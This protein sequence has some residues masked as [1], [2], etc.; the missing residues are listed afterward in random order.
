[1]CR[2]SSQ[3]FYRYINGLELSDDHRDNVTTISNL[4]TP[5][6]QWIPRGIPEHTDH[7]VL[8]SINVLGYVNQLVRQYPVPNG[9]TE[10]EK[11]IMALAA[12]LHDIGCIAGREN[13]NERTVRILSK[14]QFEF[15]RYLLGPVLYR[16]LECVI[17]SHSKQFDLNH[18]PDDPSP[19]IRLKIISSIFR[20]ADVC[21]INA[22]RIK[23]LLLDVLLEEKLLEPKSEEIWRSHLEIENIIIKENKIIP[24]IY[25]KELANSCLIDIKK[26]ID[27]VNPVLSYLGLPIFLL[28]PEIVEKSILKEP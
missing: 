24:K 21:D 6:L 11:Y 27:S 18:I 25:S 12:I 20:I 7:G 9:F 4:V 15:I 23:K 8:H 22:L 1:M 13:H 28:K 16:A 17:I 26:D 3:R 19:E 14:P 10:E 5:L 2:L